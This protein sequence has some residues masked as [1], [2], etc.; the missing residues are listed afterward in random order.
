MKLLIPEALFVEPSM[1]IVLLGPA[2]LSIVK[3]FKQLVH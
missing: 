2:A 1:G 3:G